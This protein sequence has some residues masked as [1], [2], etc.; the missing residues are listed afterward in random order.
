MFIEFFPILDSDLLHSRETVPST[1]N[2]IIQTSPSLV[3]IP[4]SCRVRST[5]PHTPKQFQRLEFAAVLEMSALGDGTRADKIFEQRD[6]FGSASG[7]FGDVC[8]GG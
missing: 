6:D 3:K 7:K 2:D 8:A 1:F 5:S 4:L